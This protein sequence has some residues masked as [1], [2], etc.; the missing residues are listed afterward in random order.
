MASSAQASSVAVPEFRRENPEKYYV[1]MKYFA[2]NPLKYWIFAIFGLGMFS[3]PPH[4]E[5]LK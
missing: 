3:L 2:E 1:N 5:S 4:L